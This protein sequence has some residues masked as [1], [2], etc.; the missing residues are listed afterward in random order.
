MRSSTA[1]AIFDGRMWSRASTQWTL[2]PG[3]PLVRASSS[4]ASAPQPMTTTRGAVVPGS[5]SGVD[6]STTLVDQAPRRL[7]GHAR[8]AAVG[9]G[10]DGHAELLVERRAA[11]EDDVVV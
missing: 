6:A 1:P 2:T 4:R 10:P 3:M 7:G 5:T 8:I 9:I 11:H